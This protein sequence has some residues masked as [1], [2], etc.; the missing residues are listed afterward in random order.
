MIR[1]GAELQISRIGLDGLFSMRQGWRIEDKMQVDGKTEELR[2]LLFLRHEAETEMG[3]LS[4]TLRAEVWSRALSLAALQWLG[5][6]L[7]TPQRLVAIRQFLGAQRVS[8]PAQCCTRQKK[9]N[10]TGTFPARDW[11]WN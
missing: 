3:E 2:C 8:D 4:E 11:A 1:P 5:A 7:V 10:L 9:P 6:C